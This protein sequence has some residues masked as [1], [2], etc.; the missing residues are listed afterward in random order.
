M[1][2]CPFC[3]E[4]KTIVIDSRWD[5]R[6]KTIRRRRHCLACSYRWTTLEV[7][8]DQINNLFQAKR[9]QNSSMDHPME[10]DPSIDSEDD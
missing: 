2:V 4:G 5:E 3:I 8:L 1:M 7:D 9:G 10:K 6:H